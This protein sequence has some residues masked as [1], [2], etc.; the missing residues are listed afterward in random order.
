[1]GWQ[2]PLPPS[3]HIVKQ[4]QQASTKAYQCGS[5]KEHGDL[6]GFNEAT[7]RQ[8]FGALILVVSSPGSLVTK[9]LRI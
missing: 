3:H 2:T 6:F 7:K 4:A 5:S 8:E 1:M 9:I